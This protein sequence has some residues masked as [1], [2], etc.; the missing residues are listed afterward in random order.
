METL[1]DNLNFSRR[2]TLLHKTLKNG[3]SWYCLFMYFYLSTTGKKSD[4]LKP[5]EKS[6]LTVTYR[7]G[8]FKEQLWLREA[9]LLCFPCQAVTSVD[10]ENLLQWT[11]QSRKQL[12]VL[13]ITHWGGSFIVP[14]PGTQGDKYSWVRLTFVF[15]A[16]SI[17]ATISKVFVLILC[18]VVGCVHNHWE[19]LLRFH[20]LLGWKVS[21]SCFHKF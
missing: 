15:P 17:P 16:T 18:L 8:T 11:I 4:L 19:T 7:M 21:K 1:W 12:G 2:Q 14:S 13:L 9:T 6:D 10:R 20:L 3:F 5:L